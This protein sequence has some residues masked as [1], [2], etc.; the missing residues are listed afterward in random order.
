MASIRSLATALILVAS[1]VTVTTT[2]A[3]GAAAAGHTAAVRS[4]AAAASQPALRLPRREHYL[5]PNKDRRQDR[6]RVTF[7][8]A[9]PAKVTVKLL[10]GQRANERVVVGPVRLGRLDA[11]KHTW[12]WD[13]RK[14]GGRKAAD[15]R[16]QL[17][18][19]ARLGNGK[20]TFA[21]GLVR[22]DTVYKPAPVTV[23]DETV[24]PQTTEVRDHILVS[25]FAGGGQ[26]WNDLP[27]RGIGRI[28]SAAG[29]LVEE[30]KFGVPG[31]APD[32]EADGFP[33]TFDG[34]DDQDRPLPA[35]TYWVRLI[36]SDRAGNRGRSPRFP[37]TVS[38]VPLVMAS[39][40]VTVTPA[41]T[42]RL[43]P[44]GAQRMRCGAVDPSARYSGGFTYRAIP[45]DECPFAAQSHPRDP[46]LSEVYSSHG[47]APN[48]VAPRGIWSQ[49]VSMRGQPTVDGE[50]DWATLENAGGTRTRTAEVAGE[51]MTTTPTKVHP[52][53]AVDYG[54]FPSASLYW[55]VMTQDGNSYD[56]AAFT[57]DYTYLTPQP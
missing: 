42:G 31:P 55:A 10:R 37:I 41:G 27:Y 33:H 29:E 43:S 57:V 13:G 20:A 45:I 4:A 14:Q 32:Y 19:K 46:A 56:V 39:G 38:P 7:K 35:G 9:R 3:A 28:K 22:V 21:Y 17:K 1:A 36:A 24:F 50:T 18:I 8:L 40:T 52:F 48:V 53:R 51:T 26:E 30:W 5:S 11:G 25:Y 49:R 44:F 6:A 16:Y 34:R 15:G 54:T 2:S 12:T 47:I 23:T